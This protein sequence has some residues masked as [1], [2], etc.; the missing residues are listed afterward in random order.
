VCGIFGIVATGRPLPVDRE[1]ARQALFTLGHR[2]PDGW[3]ELATDHAY[4]G[5]MRLAII[6]PAGGDQPMHSADGRHVVTFNGQI[7]NYRELR[8]EL[9][10]LGRRFRTASDTEVLLAAYGEWGSECLPRLRGMFAFA[11]LDSET[12]ELFAARDR[13]GIKPFFYADANGVLAFSSELKAIHRVG[14]FPLE[15]DERHFNEYLIWG[16]V[17]G[18]QTLLRGLHEL[19]P[20]HFLRFGAAGLSVARFATPWSHLDNI[21]GH[22]EES[23]VDEVSSRLEEA[24][25]FW[26]RGDVEVTSLLSG[27]LDSPLVSRLAAGVVPGLR[28]FAAVFPGDPRIDES[29]AIRR[30]ANHIGTELVTIEI[31]G[32]TIERHLNEL[33]AH[34]DEPL[35]DSNYFTLLALCRGI[36]ACSDVKVVLCGEGADELFGGY[37]RHRTVSD[38]FARTGDPD[39]LVY[40]RN[41]LSLQRLRRLTGDIEV[42]NRTR[43]E[44]FDE[45]RSSVP[46]QDPINAA[47]LLDQA[48]FLASYLHRQDRVGMRHG[49][50]IRV[51]YLDHPLTTFVN[52]LPSS[53]KIR[54]GWHKWILRRVAERRL[55]PE[56][57]WIREK[58]PL[59]S[60]LDSVIRTSLAAT[61][62]DAL[63]PGSKLASHYSPEGMLG[64]LADHN[65][66]SGGSDHGNMLWRLLSLELWLRSLEHARVPAAA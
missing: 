16:Y 12:G 13:F 66:E 51:P 65:P 39:V 47:L 60:S 62:R 45:I 5:H 18:E 6:D 61:F 64:L 26:V 63:G 23:V 44:L 38:E 59:S 56:S 21:D 17:A 4:L 1:L 50:E 15:P 55:A 31:D 14:L 53:L 46:G 52:A 41:V 40:A 3:G 37:D 11:I 8:R 32:Q 24:V 30:A 35:H 33:V 27:G 7:F 54:D 36:R 25:E 22:S 2:G 10:A 34:F 58:T 9:E 48:T 57:V 49:I 28:T 42:P 43:W 19:Q 29:V 20:G